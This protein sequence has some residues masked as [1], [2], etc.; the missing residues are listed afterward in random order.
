[1]YTRKISVSP[2]IRP[3]KST[4]LSA[5]FIVLPPKNALSRCPRLPS[6]DGNPLRDTHS[7]PSLPERSR[8]PDLQS[9][10]GSLFHSGDESFGSHFPELDTADAELAHVSFRTAGNHAAVVQT[11]GVGVARELAQTFLVA[12]RL[13]GCTFLGIP[14][15]EFLAFHLAGFHRFF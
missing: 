5:Q 7:T 15:H 10:P 4:L 8:R 1:L 9:L 3:H 13:E 6:A 14:V 2:Q 11:D 12:G